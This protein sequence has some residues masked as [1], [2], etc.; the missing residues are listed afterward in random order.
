M[1]PQCTAH[2]KSIVFIF[3][4]MDVPVTCYVC[5]QIAQPII[6]H[7]INMAFL[8]I[9]TRYAAMIAF[10]IICYGEFFPSRLILKS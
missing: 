4:M 9:N 5:Y 6:N 10:K 7:K 3:I 2:T 8:N 1:I